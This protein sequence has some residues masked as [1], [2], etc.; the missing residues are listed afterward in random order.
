MGIFFI[1]PDVD[2]ARALT[3]CLPVDVRRHERFAGVTIAR[4]A[5]S[6]VRWYK[7]SFAVILRFLL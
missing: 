1:D 2:D 3:D 7:S 4:A 5:S 6:E